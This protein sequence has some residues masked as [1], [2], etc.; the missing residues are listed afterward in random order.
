MSLDQK[1]IELVERIVY[2]NADD[3]AVSITRSFER[4]EERVDLLEGR[5][6]ARISE[7]ED[8]LEASRQDLSDSI[9]NVKEEFRDFIRFRESA[10]ELD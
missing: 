7:V 5:L 10:T 3:I 9:G 1:D 6:Y 8:R 4:L 2:K